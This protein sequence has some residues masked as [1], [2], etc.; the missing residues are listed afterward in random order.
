MRERPKGRN[1]ALPNGNLTRRR[2]LLAAAAGAG[3]AALAACRSA[4]STS[5]GG[6]AASGPVTASGP[7]PKL[8][9]PATMTPASQVTSWFA[10]SSHGGQ[11]AATMSGYYD[12]ANIKMTTDQGG[13]QEPVVPLLA[14]GK[15]T[16][17]MTGADVLL[18]AR[19]DGI[20]IVAVFA[21][22][23]LTLTGL[24]YHANHPLSGYPDLQGRKVYVT[25]TAVWWPYLVK[26]YGLDKAQQMTYNGQLQNFLADD[27]AVTQ[28]FVSTE[29]LAAKKQGVDVGLLRLADSGYNPYPNLMAT[30][31]Q[32][33]KD[34]PELVQAFVTASLQ[35]WKDYLADPTATNAYLKS[36]NKDSDVDLSNQAA[37]I[38]KPFA[39]GPSGDPKM[40]GT[41]TE[42]RWHDLHDDL[43]Q[44]GVLKADIDYKAAFNSSFIDA[45]QKASG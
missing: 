31:E 36:I 4:T 20:P 7:A 5:S 21:P 15:Y 17:G 30:T 29:P 37:A 34:K 28:C 1:R 9:Q 42:Q 27:T 10:Q 25:A 19:Q 2:L 38:E 40:L 12:K 16:F 13:P 14:S 18:Q 43:R 44:V 45:A 24:M 8:A 23:Q 11:F 6:S 26:K 41:M 22:F 35:G 3:A 39:L 33:I 32:V